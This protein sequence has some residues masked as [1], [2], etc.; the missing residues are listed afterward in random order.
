M[1]VLAQLK[2]FTHEY[3]S[4]KNK[5]K[6]KKKKSFLSVKTCHKFFVV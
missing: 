6:K 3:V 2:Q 4:G 1:F 5:A